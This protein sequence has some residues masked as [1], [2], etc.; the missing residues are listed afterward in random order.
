MVSPSH[1]RF[2]SGSALL[3]ASVALADPA[4]PIASDRFGDYA[5]AITELRQEAGQ[6]RRNRRS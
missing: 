5:A 4:Q 1:F 6:D 3:A 2:A